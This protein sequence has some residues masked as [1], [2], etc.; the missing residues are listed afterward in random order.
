[1]IRVRKSAEPPLALQLKYNHED[2]CKQMLQDQNDKCYLCEQKMIANYQVDH[3][4]PQKTAP[5]LTQEWTNLFISCGYCNGRKSATWSQI[6]NP[7]AHNIEDII[8]HSNDFV[9]KVVLFSSSD[10]FSMA[11][12]QTIELLSRLFNGKRAVGR[13]FK[14]ERFYQEYL[15][16]MN[17]FLSHINQYLSGAKDRYR[18]AIIE[19]LDRES[20]LLGFKYDIIRKNRTLYQDFGTYVVWN[21]E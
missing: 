16:K 3:L 21:K 12:A 11:T 8:Q 13:D 14:E 2:V 1:M 19:Q 18:S 9:A 15:R 20:E 17:V 10:D 7:A 4:Q 6:L 5:G